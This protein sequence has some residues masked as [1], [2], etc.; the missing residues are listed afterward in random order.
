MQNTSAKAAVFI[1]THSLTKALLLTGLH[2]NKNVP[3]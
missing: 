1:F 2:K 3:A